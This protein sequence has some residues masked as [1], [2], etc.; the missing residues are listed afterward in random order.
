MNLKLTKHLKYQCF[1]AVFFLNMGRIKGLFLLTAL[2]MC[3][4]AHVCVKCN[5]LGQHLKDAVQVPCCLRGKMLE[6]LKGTTVEQ[7]NKCKLS[8]FLGYFA[9]KQDLLLLSS[10]G[11]LSANR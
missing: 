9:K 3:V 2:Q 6:S 11:M 4:C 10:P 5:V 8:V 7:L 1:E